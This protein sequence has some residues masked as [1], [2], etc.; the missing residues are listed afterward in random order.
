MVVHFLVCHTRNFNLILLLHVFNECLDSINSL[1][2]SSN[3]FT[4]VVTLPAKEIVARLFVS[5][6][7]ILTKH[8]TIKGRLQIK[9]VLHTN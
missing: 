7:L 9:A 8:Q 2:L 1:G 6:N 3:M 4:G 5:F